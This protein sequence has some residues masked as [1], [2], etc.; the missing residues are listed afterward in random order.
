[1]IMAKP[2]QFDGIWTSFQGEL[3][4]AGIHELEKQFEGLLKERISLFND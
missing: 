2:E 3:D 1:M 4:K